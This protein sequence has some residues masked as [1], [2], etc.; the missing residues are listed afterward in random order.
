MPTKK[1]IKVIHAL[2]NALQM[3]ES[4][5]RQ[6]LVNRYGAV[7]SK[8]LN[9]DEA[10]DLIAYLEDMAV[11]AGVWEPYARK[12]KYE[13]LKGRPYMATPKQLRMIE[14]MWKDVSRHKR[15]KER[16]AALRA[17]LK[18]I[19]GVDDLRFLEDWQVP[20]VVEALRAM[21]DARKTA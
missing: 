21:R 11:E 3:S 2:K 13:D 16:E 15:T 1:Q 20:K 5:Y 4:A 12:K 19:V 18:R 8:A 17:F 6:V 10:A 14:A 9:V 7:T